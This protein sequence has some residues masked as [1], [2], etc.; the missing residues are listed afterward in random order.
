MVCFKSL[1]VFDVQEE[2]GVSIRL[3]G[4]VDN[5]PRSQQALGGDASNVFEMTSREPVD[6]RVE[7]G[8]DVLAH[9]KRVPVFVLAAMIVAA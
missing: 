7:M 8:S 6:W 5:H 4:Y 2:I 3:R 9:F 1:D